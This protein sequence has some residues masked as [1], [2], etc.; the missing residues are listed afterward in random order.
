VNHFVD[1]M[2]A[3]VIRYRRGPE[4]SWSSRGSP[5]KLRSG[6]SLSRAQ[7]V[8]A[9]TSAEGP[10]VQAAVPVRVPPWP[11]LAVLHALV[12]IPSVPLL[13]EVVSATRRHPIHTSARTHSFEYIVFSSSFIPLTHSLAIFFVTS[14]AIFGTIVSGRCQAWTTSYQL[15]PFIALLDLRAPWGWQQR[16]KNESGGVECR[17]INKIKS[18]EYMS[19]YPTIYT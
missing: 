16:E 4:R 12:T 7:E 15:T 8:V 2:F 6:T 17:R 14:C 9:R 5:S 11:T 1:S 10:R 18:S 19:E 13:P 3:E